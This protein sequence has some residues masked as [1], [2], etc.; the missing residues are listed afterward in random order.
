MPATMVSVN[1]VGHRFPPKERESPPPPPPSHAVPYLPFPSPPRHRCQNLN[2]YRR[3]LRLTVYTWV[4]RG[5]FE[6]HRL[7]FLTQVTFG[8]LEVRYTTR[9]VS[10]KDIAVVL[11]YCVW[12]PR[13]GQTE[14]M[15][16]A[17]RVAHY[18]QNYPQRI[19]N[20]SIILVC[21]APRLTSTDFPKTNGRKKCKGSQ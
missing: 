11:C 2:L 1:L 4:T 8:L 21:T 18:C 7:I 14:G 5:L 19:L 17:N 15:L 10:H 20:R 12:G 6:K 16:R 9:D 13:V 3:S